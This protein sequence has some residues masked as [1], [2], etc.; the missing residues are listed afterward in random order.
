MAYPD[1]F[2]CGAFAMVD[3][4]VAHV[5][6]AG[7]AEVAQ[8]REVLEKEPGV[9]AVLDRKAQRKEGIAHERSGDLMLV[10]RPGR[11]FAYPWWTERKEAPDYASHVDIHNKP[12][13]DPCELFFG[14]PPPSVSQDTARIKG[15]HGRAGEG[16][17]VAWAATFDLGAEPANLVDLAEAL[18]R[19]LDRSC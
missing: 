12:G 1:F 18:K 8:A 19:W 3:H 6:C 10:A 14:F 2:A 9:G 7:E 11:W 4:E 13:F 5:F 15:S 16:A 17:E